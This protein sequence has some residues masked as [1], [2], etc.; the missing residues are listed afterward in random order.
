MEARE[1]AKNAIESARLACEKA[2]AARG[3]AGMLKLVAL[4]VVVVVVV[5]AVLLLLLKRQRERGKLG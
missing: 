5:I 3:F 1:E 4:A 2:S